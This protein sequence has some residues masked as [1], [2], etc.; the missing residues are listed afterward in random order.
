MRTSHGEST[1]RT[2]LGGACVRAALFSIGCRTTSRDAPRT[3]N[4][5]VPRQPDVSGAPGGSQ[6]LDEALE[7]LAT[8]GPAYQGGLANHAPMVAEVLVTLGAD[9]VARGL[10][11]AAI[12]SRDEHAIKLTEVAMRENASAQDPAFH[13]AA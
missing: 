8:R 2:F 3:E 6:A 4:P 5:A 10:V 1:R 12:D 13:L 9:A 7:R 11:A